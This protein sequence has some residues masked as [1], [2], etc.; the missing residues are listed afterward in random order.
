MKLI[1]S[2][3]RSQASHEMSVTQFRVLANIN[4]HD[5]ITVTQLAHLTDVSKAGMSR[6]VTE[7]VKKRFVTRE[8]SSSD[9]RQVVLELS[10]KGKTYFARIK[11]DV[12]LKLSQRFKA[13][14]DINCK[15]ILKSLLILEKMMT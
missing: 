2:E 5:T 8:V 12:E 9:R 11:G 15:C 7:L 4:L 3:M 1:R 14:S 13:L 10:V 6:M